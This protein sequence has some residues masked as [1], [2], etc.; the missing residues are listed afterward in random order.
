MYEPYTRQSLPENEYRELLGTAI[1]VFNQNFAF[2]VEIIST[3]YGNNIDNFDWY[4]LI[5][6]TAGEFYNNV[7]SK[8]NNEDVNLALEEFN[9]VKDKRD[10][11]VHSFGITNTENKQVLQTKTKTTKGNIQTEITEEYLFDFI[12]DNDNLSN[13]LYELREKLK[14][15]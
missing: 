1:Y 4:H 8:I 11:I 15:Q 7:K 14:N 12:K 3:Y 6:M 2:F 13:K 10:R 9:K 5:D